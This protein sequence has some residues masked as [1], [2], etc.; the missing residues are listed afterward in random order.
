MSRWS[1]SFIQWKKIEISIFSEIW[2]IFWFWERNSRKVCQ[3]C[4][5][6]TFPW[7]VFG[8]NFSNKILTVFWIWTKSFRT[9]SEKIWQCCQ[10]F[11]VRVQGAI[12][13]ERFEKHFFCRNVKSFGFFNEIKL[14][15]VCK[16]HFYVSKGSFSAIFCNNLT[17]W[18][19]IQI[20]S[21]NFSAGSSELY[22]SRPKKRFWEKDYW[23]RTNI[24]S[25][26]SHNKKYFRTL[27]QMFF[28][29][30]VV[31]TLFCLSEETI[32]SRIFK[33]NILVYKFLWTLSEKNGCCF[34]NQFYVSGGSIWKH[35]W[36]NRKLQIF[37]HILN[38][39]A[40]LHL[41]YH[42]KNLRV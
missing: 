9:F 30:V 1:I 5:R 7:K 42:K 21:G 10:N 39:A 40:Q 12:L 38:K 18:K 28:G 24:F 11:I 13:E 34:R 20:M 33:K 16:N 8:E 26:I 29:S 35:F 14:A 22:S 4:S 37:N 19:F 3:K 36:K 41:R 25:S 32:S 2:E 17:L 15:S 23:K 27:N 31:K 6:S